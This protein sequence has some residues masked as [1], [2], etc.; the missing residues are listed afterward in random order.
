MQQC[1]S[2]FE[3]LDR[4]MDSNILSDQSDCNLVVFF[5]RIIGCGVSNLFCIA[6]SSKA[7]PLLLSVV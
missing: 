3:V 6:F 1:F 5:S 2:A 7:Y 4:G